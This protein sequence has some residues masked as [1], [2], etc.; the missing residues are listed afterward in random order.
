MASVSLSGR[1]V[2]ASMVK[3]MLRPSVPASLVVILPE[4]VYKVAGLSLPL[5]QIRRY[6]AFSHPYLNII[7][8]RSDPLFA[9]WLR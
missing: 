3:Y 1:C 6:L 2:V 8:Q 5:S 4:G 7:Q 9:T